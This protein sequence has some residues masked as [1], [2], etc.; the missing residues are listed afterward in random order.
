M[1]VHFLVFYTQILIHDCSHFDLFLFLFLQ[2]SD[3][4]NAFLTDIHDIEYRYPSSS[5][6]RLLLSNVWDTLHM[7]YV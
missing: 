6:N 3:N 5:I 7:R 4:P 2:L 1:F